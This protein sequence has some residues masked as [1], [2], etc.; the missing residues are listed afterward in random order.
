MCMRIPASEQV[1]KHAGSH[2]LKDPL[3]GC[4]EQVGNKLPCQGCQS[5]WP[6]VTAQQ[7][8]QTLGHIVRQEVGHKSWHKLPGQGCQGVWP[9]DTAQ[10]NVEAP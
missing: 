2:L 9:E 4:L 5:G 10:D 8:V 6:E 1:N 3:T 7:K